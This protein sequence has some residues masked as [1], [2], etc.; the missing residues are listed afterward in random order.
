MNSTKTT[1]HSTINNVIE[2]GGERHEW[3]N[4]QW[5]SEYRNLLMG[6]AILIIVP[7]HFTE[8]G[9]STIFD[10]ILFDLFSQGYVGVD[11]FMV[12]SGLGLT[13]SCLNKYD[14]KDYYI[15]RWVRVFPFY[16]FITLIEYWCIKGESFRWAM[17]RATTLGYW[18]GFSYA[19]WFIPALVGLY[20]IFPLIFKTI[21]EPKR[22][23]TALSIGFLCLAA[24][25]LIAN[26]ELTEWDYWEHLAFVYRIPDFLTGCMAAT[27][28]NHGYDKRVVLRFVLISGTL[29]IMFLIFKIGKEYYLWFTN[30]GLTPFYLLVLCWFFN[31]LKKFYLGKI[32]LSAI[33]F[34]G[35]IT[36]ELYRIS[37]SFERLLTNEAC[38]NFHAFYV[39]LW[40]F[41]SIILSYIAH[42]I[43][44]RINKILLHKLVNITFK[45]NS[46]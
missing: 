15:K 19:D 21:V 22:Y 38:P 44:K 42:L 1:E 24:S 2:R 35:L 18:F 12:V 36:L 29:G 46:T 6:F 28:I 13:Y 34:T 11:I 20:M 32:I 37:S 30:L 10:R 31:K 16:I 23:W 33:G 8:R 14:L 3:L 27:A 7:Y 5:L 25:I 45:D 9:G 4:L 41:V 39:F 17:L 40:L 26:N 43:F